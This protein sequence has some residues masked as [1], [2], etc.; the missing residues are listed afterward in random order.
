M[1]YWVGDL[2]SDD[3]LGRHRL[4]SLRV[5]TKSRGRNFSGLNS[6]QEFEV[7]NSLPSTSLSTFKMNHKSISQNHPKKLKTFKTSNHPKI[8]KNPKKPKIFK[9]SQNHPNPASSHQTHSIRLNSLRS[10]NSTRKVPLSP[11]LS[12]II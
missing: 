1:G 5:S 3:I 8:L 10:F 4:Q 6:S 7:N 9:K 11:P 2:R 12:L